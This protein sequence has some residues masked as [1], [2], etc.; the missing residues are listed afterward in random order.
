MDIPSRRRG[1]PPVPDSERR[2]HFAKTRL[3]DA[4]RTRLDEALAA[5]GITESELLRRLSLTWAAETTGD[6]AL[7]S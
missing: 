5:A 1:R 6:L 3:N 4:E 2:K 7:V